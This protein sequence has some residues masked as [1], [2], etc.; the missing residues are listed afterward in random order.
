MRMFNFFVKALATFFYAG[1]FPLI[2]GTFASM[3]GLILLFLIKGNLF[4]YGIVTA[5]LLILGFLVAGQ[6][7]RIFQQKDSR[8]IV[9]DEAAGMFLSLAFMP[10][11][12]R[13]LLI[14]FFLFRLLDTLKPFPAGRLQ[15][16]KG[17]LGIMID[18]IVAAFY[19][20]IILQIVFRFASF[21]A[22]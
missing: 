21:K 1:F 22:S 15:N 10:H 2:P 11:D 8:H 7:E 3:L 17:S 12:K 5:V 18:D 9:I 6:A 16:L 19:T 13:L 4:I 14:G 20:N